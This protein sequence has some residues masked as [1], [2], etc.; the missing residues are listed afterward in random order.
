MSL[1]KSS[2][3]LLPK[4]TTFHN[5]SQNQF[6]KDS[7]PLYEKIDIN[8]EG[9]LTYYSNSDLQ[10]SPPYEESHEIKKSAP[11]Y[12]TD[13]NS[14]KNSLLYEEC[15]LD[16]DTS[17]INMDSDFIV[18]SLD[19]R[20]LEHL[21]YKNKTPIKDDYKKKVDSYIGSISTNFNTI[22]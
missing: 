9:L 12:F 11:T 21:N 8:K 4:D 5:N 20:S 19:T 17:P 15:Y 14:D 3:N 22:N 7:S 1:L 16:R 13:S 18:D 6:N 10:K 2:R